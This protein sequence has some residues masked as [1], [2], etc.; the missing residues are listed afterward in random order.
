M[1]RFLCQGLLACLLLAGS[2]TPSQAWGPDG[3][4]IV[5]KIAEEHMSPNAAR[6]L[7]ILFGGDVSLADL[8]N[9]AD[10]IKEERPETLPWHYTNIPPEATDLD[11]KRDCPNDECIT[12]QI[13]R[14]EGIVRLGMRTSEERQEA[15]KFLVHFAGDLHQ[16][17]HA[18]YGSDRG[19]LDVP[20]V[21]GGRQSDLHAFWDSTSV[22]LI[23]DDKAAIAARLARSVTP[24]QKKEWQQGGLRHWTW[25][26]H[27]LA[28]RVV[29]AGLP[30]GNPKQLDEDYARKAASVAEEQ[31]AKAGIRL[32]KLLDDVW[33]N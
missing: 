25:E 12:A 1:R 10:E 21:F 7:R 28:V 20:V 14:L 4:W 11:M 29:Y 30:L 31:L 27:L 2:A 3:H 17:L 5:G 24:A 33:A 16:P 19:G 9:W 23:S 32:A 13:R 26:S 8:A 15:L 22:G 18:G 6:R